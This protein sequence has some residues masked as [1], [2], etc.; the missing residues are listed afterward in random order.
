MSKLTSP[1][2]FLNLRWQVNEVTR[3]SISNW[4]DSAGYTNYAVALLRKVNSKW[5]VDHTSANEFR[6]KD[7]KDIAFRAT[8]YGAGLVKQVL[9]ECPSRF[10]RDTAL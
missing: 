1:K 5:E 6:G 8:D 10:F 9:G 4:S 2:S 7:V 3:L